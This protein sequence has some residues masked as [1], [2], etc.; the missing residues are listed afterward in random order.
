MAVRGVDVTLYEMKPGKFSAAHTNPGFAELVCSN[1]LG[2]NRVETASGLLKE[3]MRRLGSLI[4]RCADMSAV[5][6]GGALAVDRELFSARVTSEITGCGRI[7]IISGE[8]EDIPE[9]D[10]VIV[11]TGPLT[12]GA[13]ADSISRALGGDE[14]IEFFDAVAP[15]VAADSVDMSKAYYKSRYDR[16][17]P[18][19]I[20]CP[21]DR[22]EYTAFWER[23]KTA[24]EAP[25]HGFE[26]KLVYEGCM[27]VEV[28]ARRGEDALRYG[29]MKPIG[30]RDP[31]TEKTPYAVVQLRRD[32]VS[33]A[34]F[35]MVGFQT[36]LTF[37]EQRAVFSMIPGLERAEFL[38]YGVMHRNT[39]INSPKLLDRHYMVRKRP[40][41]FFAGQITGVEGYAESASSGLMA[42][43]CASFYLAGESMPDLPGTTAIGALPLYI[44]N[45]GTS[46]FQPMGINYGIIAPLEKRISKKDK[47]TAVAERS[48]GVLDLL[49]GGLREPEDIVR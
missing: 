20:N 4:V 28:L 19:Y 18:D 27:P 42:G 49:A 14:F 5:P 26:D 41:L 37:P 32:D 47:K 39:F 3:E 11:A 23:L 36:H 15:I 12:S 25:V 38:R 31:K 46:N 30:L 9:G 13:M 48:L 22:E 33:G 34:M 7:K 44:S 21:M 2:A 43:L 29:P 16:G 17:T 24:Q 35:N 6:A 8:V 10:C 40:G 1:S 45:P